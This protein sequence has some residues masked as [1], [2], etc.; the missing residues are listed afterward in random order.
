MA[1]IGVIVTA[2]VAGRAGAAATGGAIRVAVYW[3]RPCRV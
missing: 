2:I 3:E 1:R